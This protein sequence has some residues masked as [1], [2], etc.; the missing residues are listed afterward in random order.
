MRHGD[1]LR[2]LRISRGLTQSQLAAGITHRTTLAS[3]EL[4][5]TK[6]DFE[7]MQKYLDR[8]NVSIEEYEYM[9]NKH[10][11]ED[12]EKRRREFNKLLA[13]KGLT[14]NSPEILTFSEEMLANYQ[15]TNDWFYYCMYAQINLII[16]FKK[17]LDIDGTPKLATMKK[18]LCDYL[19][20][21]NSWTHFEFTLFINC[22][23]TF[24]DEFI[25]AFLVTSLRAAHLY[26][27]NRYFEG[28]IDILLRNLLYLATTRH[29]KQ[30]F[31]FAY[32]EL[33]HVA[34]KSRLWDIRIC[35][36]VYDYVKSKQLGQ[37]TDTDLGD[38]CAKLEWLGNIGLVN[39]LKNLGDD[40]WL[41]S[42]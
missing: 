32:A 42:N 38:L 30:I 12:K 36:H 15:V 39:L 8:L 16:A 7:T 9:Y 13:K 14:L 35:K 22:L 37:A 26:A 11:A 28:D 2:Q 40:G 29:N 21:V 33:T 31:D 1:L 3:F 20:G 6:I 10:A 4:Q 23:F 41:R 18:R 5:G 17:G 27:N 34:A 19:Q 25:E 24:E